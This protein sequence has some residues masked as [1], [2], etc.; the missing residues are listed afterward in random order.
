MRRKSLPGKNAVCLRIKR[1]VS[2][3]MDQL[4]PITNLTTSLWSNSANVGLNS[5]TKAYLCAFFLCSSQSKTLRTPV[6][7]ISPVISAFSFLHFLDFFLSAIWGSEWNI[8]KTSGWI[9]MKFGTDIHLP[10]RMNFADPLTSNQAPP[11]GQIFN[12]SETPGWL[13]IF[14]SASAVLCV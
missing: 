12:L 6:I 8:S 13:K 3:K 14:P 7:E 10:L 11:S 5:F 9:A 2:G 1:D 4:L